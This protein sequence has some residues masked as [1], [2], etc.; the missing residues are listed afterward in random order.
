MGVEY[1]SFG[2]TGVELNDSKPIRVKFD[3]FG[4]IGVE[5]NNSNQ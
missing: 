3:S 1:S 4:P 5:H 2:P